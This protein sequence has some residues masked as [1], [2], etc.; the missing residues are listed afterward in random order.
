MYQLCRISI[1]IMCLIQILNAQAPDTLWTKTY[2]GSEGDMLQAI[3]R[4]ADGDFVMAGGLAATGSTGDYW[5]IKTDAQGDTLWTRTYGGTSWENCRSMQMTSDDGFV[6]VGATESFGPNDRNIWLVRTDSNGDTSWTKT[7][8]KSLLNDANSV[9]QTSDSGFIVVGETG[10]YDEGSEDVYLVRTDSDGDTLWTKTYGGSNKDISKSVQQTADSGYIVLANR[11]VNGNVDI[12]LLK[13]DANGDTTWTSTFHTGSDGEGTKVVQTADSGYAIFGIIF[14]TLDSPAPEGE[15][16]DWLLIKTDSLGT[17]EWSQTYGGDLSD[18]SMDMLLLDDD[19]FLLSG[20]LDQTDLGSSA[21]LW[22]V[23]VDEFGDIVWATAVGGD[24][25]DAGTGLAQIA[26]DEYAVVGIT[27]SWGAGSY[28]GWLVRFGTPTG[29]PPFEQDS[30]ALVALYNSTNGSTDWLTDTNWLTTEPLNTWYGVTVTDGRVTEVALYDNN[31]TGTIPTEIGDLTE[32]TN[33]NLNNNNLSGN[34]PAEIGS[35]AK[36]T[37]LAL[38]NNDLSGNIPTGIGNLTELTSLGLSNN[39]LS[40]NLPAEI[41]SLT[42]LGTISLLNNSLS[43]PIPTGIGNLIVLYDL[44][45]GGNQFT[46]LPAEIGNLSELKYLAISDNQL[47]TLPPEIGSLP[48]LTNLYLQSNQ[49][50]ALPAEIGNLPSLRTLSASNNQLIALPPEIGTLSSLTSLSVDYN[51]LTALP[52]EIGNLSSLTRLYL[53]KNQLATLP[54]EIGNLSSLKMLYLYD[55]QLTALPDLSGLTSLERLYVYDNQ[56]TFEDIEPI[57]NLASITFDY[58]PQDSVGTEIDTTL[59]VGD[60]LT[61]SVSV[62]G[63]NNEYQWIKGD[64]VITDATDDTLI[65]SSLQFTDAGYY[66][67]EITNTLATE[68]I[69]YSWPIHVLVEGTTYTDSLALVALYDST[70]GANWTKNDGWLDPDSILDTWFGIKV[71]NGRVYDVRLTNNNLVGSIPPAIGDFTALE[72]LYL[73]NNQLT[74]TIPDEI[75]NLTALETLYLDNNQLTG[76]I[77]SEI[78][79]LTSLYGLFLNDNELNGEIPAAIGDLGNL[80]TL[81]LNENNLTGLIPPTIGGLTGM[82]TLSLSSNELSGGIPSAIGDL[83]NLRNLDMS[84]NQLTDSIPSEIVNFPEL[85]GLDLGNN[86]LTGPIPASIGTHPKLRNL[87]LAGNEL[88]GPIPPEIGNDTSL[89]YLNLGNNQLSGPIPPDIGELVNLTYLSLASNKLTALPS[90]IDSL[91]N[92]N[93]LLLGDNLLT[94]IP[95]DIGG[96]VNLAELSLSENQLASLPDEIGLIPSLTSLSLS[97]NLLDSLPDL[98]GDTSL[99]HLFLDNNR[100]TFEDIEPLIGLSIPTM[101]YHMQDSVGVAMDT[102]VDFGSE[103]ALS[104]DVGGTANKYQWLR[105][106]AELTGDTSATYTITSMS[107]QDTGT[108]VCSIS[109]TIAT[110]LILYSRPV[111][112][113]ISGV[114]AIDE[115]AGIPGEYALHANYPNPF[116]PSTTIRYDLPEAVE[117]TL[118][119]YDLLGRE[120]VRLVDQRLEA[121]YHQLVWNGRDRAGRELPTGMYIVTMMTPEYSRAIKMVLLK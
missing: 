54:P 64:V 66:A 39:N 43:G 51:Q 41:G 48:A 118:V 91:I 18:Q 103:L 30:L 110:G 71:A 61:M 4:T 77:P 59:L 1:T 16:R 102:T 37:G 45:L 92:L 33:L 79:N 44:A 69:L 108:Y 88:T 116:N 83:V 113:T 65:I 58:S 36:L 12:W 31:L 2:G 32:L 90:T 35:L 70:N 72:F 38:S 9:V 20:W 93:Y 109:N 28:D 119:V 80:N 67:C 15:D 53:G 86:N 60:E 47:T 76:T 29:P 82:W 40:G 104:V 100:L 21:D 105:N 94:S 24:N 46:S 56:L 42:K 112:V 120:V 25:L 84:S 13:T 117:V 11:Q 27:D 97:F 115:L 106:A 98:S 114:V 62:G 10:T 78:G 23:R 75:G 17:L 50:T 73:G 8:G 121:G 3:Q 26:E 14:G 107:Y 22:L 5:L 101:L 49:L 7:F 52:T 55:N 95:S 87:D 68:L 111:H 99:T 85:L 63:D 89:A 74:G 96:L 81:L 57:L 34:L 6:L 19:G